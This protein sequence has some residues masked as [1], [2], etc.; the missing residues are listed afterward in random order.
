M[1][2]WS[3]GE[4]GGGLGLRLLGAV[5]PLGELAELRAGGALGV[6]DAGLERRQLAAELRHAVLQGAGWRPPWRAAERLAQQARGGGGAGDGADRER[7]RDAGGERRVARQAP[8]RCL[9]R[10]RRSVSAGVRCRRRAAVRTASRSMIGL[11]AAARRPSALRSAAAVASLDAAS[12]GRVRRPCRWPCAFGSRLMD[13]PTGNRDLLTRL[14]KRL[15]TGRPFC[16]AS[17]FSETSGRAPM[18]WIT[19]AA[20]SAPSCAAVLWSRPRASPNRKPAANRSPA[21]VASTSLLDRRRRHRDR[22]V[23]ADDDAALLAARHHRELARRRAAPSPRC[24]NRRSRR[25]S[26]ARFR[27]RTPD[28]PC[29]S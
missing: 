1:L 26:S 18:C 21:P 27:W 11:S 23:L 29:R 2:S 24:R 10:R 9:A 19:S 14:L 20:A 8:A 4:L 7:E 13:L 3:L 22:A 5:E 15:Q 28:R 25:G 17:S 6:G 16:L 12:V